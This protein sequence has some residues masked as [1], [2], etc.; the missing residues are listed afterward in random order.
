MDKLVIFSII[1]FTFNSAFGGVIDLETGEIIENTDIENIDNT[2]RTK[3]NSKFGGIPITDRDTLCSL[4][5]GVLDRGIMS[6]VRQCEML[7]SQK[8]T[9]H[10]NVYVNT[11]IKSLRLSRR[12]LQRVRPIHYRQMRS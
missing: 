3:S 1:L 7:A 6:Q 4:S 9:G 2:S 5:Y 12:V 10:E 11:I 8:T